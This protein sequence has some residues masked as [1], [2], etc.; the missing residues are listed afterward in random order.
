MF[1]LEDVSA[2]TIRTPVTHAKS[3]VRFGLSFQAALKGG[4]WPGSAGEVAGA[5]NPQS[6]RR[7]HIC[8]FGGFQRI[9]DVDTEV[10]HFALDPAVTEQQL[11]GA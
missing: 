5:S 2:A 11:H 6:R 4:S 10:A 1:A 8:L 9:I 3:G 7:D